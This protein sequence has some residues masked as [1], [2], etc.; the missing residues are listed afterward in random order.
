[1]GGDGSQTETVTSDEVGLPGRFFSA[2][3][4]N[5][6]RLELVGYS[7]DG[8]ELAR[9]GS[10]APPTGPP[11][12]RAEAM[13]QGDPAGFAPAIAPPSSYEYQGESIAPAEAARLE[14]VCTQEPGV[15]RCYDSES[16]A[17]AA[18][19]AGSQAR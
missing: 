13:A 7:A 12:S 15:M 1:L 4:P 19:R 9:L 11:L 10:L 8:E 16:E 18:A 17:E 5:G 3:A 14:L 6:G 2:V